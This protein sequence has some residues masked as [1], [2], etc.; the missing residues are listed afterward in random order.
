MQIGLT[1]GGTFC[2]TSIVA[3]AEPS[4]QCILVAIACSFVF[5]PH[6]SLFFVVRSSGG[7]PEPPIVGGRMSLNGGRSARCVGQP[8]LS[9]P[10]LRLRCFDA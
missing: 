7:S 3:L 9:A 6:L 5:P 10:P 4:F 2:W 1:R 8:P